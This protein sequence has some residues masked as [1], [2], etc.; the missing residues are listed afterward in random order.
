MC[1]F[2]RRGSYDTP[3][4]GLRKRFRNKVIRVAVALVPVTCAGVVEGEVCRFDVI[5]DAS[6][7]GR[8]T[9]ECGSAAPGG[10]PETVPVVPRNQAIFVVTG[11]N[12]GA[13]RRRL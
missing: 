12:R 8:P 10:V 1:R 13:V 7:K 3:C 6:D 11:I 5:A 9:V 4:M 2:G